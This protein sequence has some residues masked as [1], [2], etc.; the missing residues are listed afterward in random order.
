[1][2]SEKTIDKVNEIAERMSAEKIET[3]DEGG[4]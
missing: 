1:M 3:V 2:L 4:N